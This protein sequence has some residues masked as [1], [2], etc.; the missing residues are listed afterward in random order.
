MVICCIYIYILGMIPPNHIGIRIRQCKDPVMDTP[1]IYME[2]T[3]SCPRFRL[4]NPESLPGSRL[5]SV[6]FQDLKDQDIWDLNRAR[7]LWCLWLHGW[8]TSPKNFSQTKVP[9]KE[10]SI[11]QREKAEKVFQ[12][13]VLRGLAGLFFG[14]LIRLHMFP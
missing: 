6:F 2:K 4:G 11:F 12:A 9:Q 7:E 8:C 1:R 13:S 5:P 10:G 3:W 14:R